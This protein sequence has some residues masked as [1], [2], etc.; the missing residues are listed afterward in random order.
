MID[1]LS[2]EKVINDKNTGF[3]SCDNW[4]LNKQD[5][6]SI[7]QQ[8]DTVSFIIVDNMFSTLP[9]EYKGEVRINNEKYKFLINAGAY[10]II[11]NSDTTFYLGYFEKNKYFLD[12]VYYEQDN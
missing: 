1:V 7:I 12:S 2:L 9:C 10:S 4:T 8:S 3:I 6:I 5:I 11:Y